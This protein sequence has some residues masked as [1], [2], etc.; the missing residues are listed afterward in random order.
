[1]SKKQ[2]RKAWLVT[3]EWTG[4]HAAVPQRDIVAAVINSQIG[5]KNVKRFV[6]HLYAAR[7]YEAVEKLEALSDNPYPARFGT[8]QVEVSLS[9]GEVVQQTVSFDGQV[10]C[11]HNPYLYARLVENLRAKDPANSDAGLVWDEVPKP[12]IRLD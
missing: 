5:P 6:E 9:D 1:M 4:E 7:K 2:G 12:S 8:I 10:I 11:G 3:W